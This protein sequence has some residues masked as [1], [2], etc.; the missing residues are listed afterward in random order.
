[1]NEI[2]DDAD[3][4]LRACAGLD[5]DAFDPEAR[6]GQL[7][8][9]EP[10][11][12]Q[13][14]VLA[15]GAAL[16]ACTYGGMWE[17]AAG[18]VFDSEPGT[19]VGLPQVRTVELKGGRATFYAFSG[20]S[21][22]AEL[23]AHAAML[24]AEQAHLLDNRVTADASFALGEARRSMLR[25]AEAAEP[26]RRARELAEVNG[27][28]NLIATAVA[29]QANI[30]VDRGEPDRATELIDRLRREHPHRYPPTVAGL[31]DAAAARALV[32]VG[33]FPAA[34]RILQGSP[35]TPAVASARVAAL[36]GAGDVG[37][38]KATVRDW[39]AAPTVD[40]TVRR[41]LAAAVICDQTGERG[42]AGLLR[43]ALDAATPHR[44]L[45][46]FIEFGPN[47]AR[48]LRRVA[49]EDS[50]ALAELHRWLGSAGPAG[51]APRFTAREAMVMSLVAEGHKLRE[52]AD[53]IHLSVNT[54]RTHV[55]SAYRKL[56]VD[57][58]ADAIRAWR[59]LEDAP[60][61]PR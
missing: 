16:L 18:H 20:R 49:I 48:L 9:G 19:R 28:V 30:A 12:D 13:F 15:H 34:V 54:V 36:L 60:D 27:R 47:A 7:W 58:R 3:R 26:L 14:R 53:A 55:Q 56:G 31:L 1:M 35:A 5:D 29:A 6:A 21:I 11:T 42:G 25:H 23:E 4:A 32:A 10:S 57:N 41:S 40:S 17:R 33:R 24:V 39:P 52:V 61:T 46:P 2:A 8:F 37:A 50:P 44:L 51:T 22:D 59:A 43:A 38:A 45:Q